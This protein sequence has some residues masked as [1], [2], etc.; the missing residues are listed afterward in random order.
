MFQSVTMIDLPTFKWWMGYK[1]LK[2][3]CGNGIGFQMILSN[4]NSNHKEEYT[5]PYNI[6]V[7]KWDNFYIKLPTDGIMQTTENKS[8]SEWLR[9]TLDY[10]PWTKA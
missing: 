10:F 3:Q 1:G 8:A 2:N 5:M 6:K 7:L 4:I 9:Y